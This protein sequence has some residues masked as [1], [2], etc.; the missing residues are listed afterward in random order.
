MF[1]RQM[2]KPGNLN[3]LFTNL[4]N[5]FTNILI[6]ICYQ[7]GLNSVSLCCVTVLID[8]DATSLWKHVN[9]NI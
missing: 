8:S 6:L 4:K 7:N 9:V 2:C 5:D 3:F 1:Q